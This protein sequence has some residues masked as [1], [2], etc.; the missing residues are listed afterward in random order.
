MKQYMISVW[1][2]DGE[3]QPSKYEMQQIFE[4]VD[5]FNAK[6]AAEGIGVFV[7]A[8]PLQEEAAGSRPLTP[9]PDRSTATTCCTPPAVTRSTGSADTTRRPLRSS[10]LRPSPPTSPRSNC[11]AAAAIRP[12]VDRSTPVWCLP[13]QT[14]R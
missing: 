7:E 2:V 8:G 13:V 1:H 11:L 12:A 9:S 3:E 6:V 5:A 14:L 10:R 4:D